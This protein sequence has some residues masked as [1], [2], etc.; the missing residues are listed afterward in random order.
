MEFKQS[1]KLYSASKTTPAVTGGKC[2]RNLPG[3]VILAASRLPIYRFNKNHRNQLL[4]PSTK[5][6]RS[7]L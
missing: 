2:L 6:Q 4:A 7:E 3:E 5:Q 1:K